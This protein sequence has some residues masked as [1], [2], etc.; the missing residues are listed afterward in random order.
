MH[1]DLPTLTYDDVYTAIG[2]LKYHRAGT[3][4]LSECTLDND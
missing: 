3:P 4:A 1:F 2:C